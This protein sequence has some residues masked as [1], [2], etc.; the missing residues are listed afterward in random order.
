MFKTF[1]FV[2]IPLMILLIINN[3]WVHVYAHI[4]GL[5]TLFF[6]DKT[7]EMKTYNLINKSYFYIYSLKCPFLVPYYLELEN[8]VILKT[9]LLTIM[10][11]LPGVFYALYLV[12]TKYSVS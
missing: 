8:R 3:L 2:S 6:I 1:F 5:T 11:W 9:F 10:G 4:F 12:K 7:Q